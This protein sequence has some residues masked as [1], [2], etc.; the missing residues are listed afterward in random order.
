ML[1]LSEVAARSATLWLAR[2]W[3][4]SCVLATCSPS[5]PFWAFRQQRDISGEQWALH[6]SS[7][8]LGWG[9][10]ERPE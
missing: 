6:G 8:R 3:P 5:S 10:W 1:D 9:L 2:G 7:Q 4:L